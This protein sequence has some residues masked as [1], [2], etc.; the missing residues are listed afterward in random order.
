M[1]REK[2]SSFSM[3]LKAVN[4][5]SVTPDV[6][7]MVLQMTG[8]RLDSGVFGLIAE[9]IKNQGS[10]SLFDIIEDDQLMTEVE[11]LLDINSQSGNHPSTL[12]SDSISVE[13]VIRCPHCSGPFAIIDAPGLYQK[14]LE[15]QSDN[16]KE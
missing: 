11:A 9:V 15:R 5:Q 8:V 13:A 3:I 7:R 1:L 16:V 4:A 10:K 2:L 12:S 6:V 14:V